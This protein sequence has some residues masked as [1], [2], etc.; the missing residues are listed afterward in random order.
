MD[1]VHIDAIINLGIPHVAEEI[2]VSFSDDDLIQCLKVSET[3]KGFAAKVLLQKWRG[4]LFKA[5]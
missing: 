3:W 1:S 4:Q 2:F 5:C